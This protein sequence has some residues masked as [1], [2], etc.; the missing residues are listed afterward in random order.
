MSAGL[1]GSHLCFF[2]LCASDE[3]TLQPALCPVGH[4]CPAGMILG[5]EFPCPPGTVQSQ[6]GAS[7]SDACLSCPPGM[8]KWKICLQHKKKKLKKREQERESP[9]IL[10][11]SPLLFLLFSCRNVLLSVWSVTT[12]RSLSGRIFL[13]CRI[14]QPELDR[15]SGV[16]LVFCFLCGLTKIFLIKPRTPT[17]HVI[18]PW[19]WRIRV[20]KGTITTRLRDCE[21]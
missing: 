16:E 14:N 13:S 18:K 10:L 6:L 15:V 7:S 11:T 2:S 4:Y 17:S 9:I 5:L 8:E 3:G 19:W 12:H 1:N 20:S 21:K